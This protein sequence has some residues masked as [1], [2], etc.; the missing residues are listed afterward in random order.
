MRLG[1]ATGK[2]PVRSVRRQHDRAVTAGW[3]NRGPDGYGELPGLFDP[4]GSVDRRDVRSRWFGGLPGR[5]VPLVRRIAGLPY[6]FGGSSG[7]SV[8]ADCQGCPNLV[9]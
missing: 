9:G 6:W 7:R 2:P 1:L 4:V 3:R 5:S 8:T